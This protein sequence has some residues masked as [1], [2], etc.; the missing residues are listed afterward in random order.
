MFVAFA[1]CSLLRHTIVS[2]FIC[3]IICSKPDQCRIAEKLQSVRTE[4]SRYAFRKHAYALFAGQ[5]VDG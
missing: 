3:K 1:F 2:G 4:T 5:A